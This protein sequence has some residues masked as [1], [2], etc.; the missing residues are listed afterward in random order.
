[1]SADLV[2]CECY[3]C[4]PPTDIPD[5]EDNCSVCYVPTGNSYPKVPAVGTICI[6]CA[7]K[8]SKL[9]KG[10]LIRDPGNRQYMVTCTV[11]GDIV[12]RFNMGWHFSGHSGITGLQTMQEFANR[13]KEI[14]ILNNQEQKS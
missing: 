14:D 8:I 2:K 7:A 9:H 13:I 1:M 4:K 5:G 10:G 11:C 6:N 3:G 12:H